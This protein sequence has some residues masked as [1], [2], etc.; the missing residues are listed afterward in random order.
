MNNKDMIFNIYYVNFPKV[1]EIKTDAQQHDS[2]WTTN[3][4]R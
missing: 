4:E 3:R 1:Y 2:F